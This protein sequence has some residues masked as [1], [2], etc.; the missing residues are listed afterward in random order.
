MSIRRDPDLPPR[1][2]GFSL[3]RRSFVA[4]AGALAAT[5]ALG[6]RAVAQAGERIVV[7]DPG[8]PFGKAFAI[9]FHEPF[10]KETGIESVQIAR[11]HEP[12]AQV[13]AIVKTKNYTWDVVTLTLSA[14]LTA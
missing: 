4:G 12:T 10:K 2:L 3:D 5:S 1:P 9:A 7:A 11:E 6:G 14:R 8:G 13:A